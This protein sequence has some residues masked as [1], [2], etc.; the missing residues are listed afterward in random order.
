L[1]P[2]FLGNGKFGAMYSGEICSEDG[3]RVGRLVKVA[4]KDSREDFINQAKV[5]SQLHHPN[6]LTIEAITSGSEPMTLVYEPAGHGSLYQYLI[7]HSPNN[8]NFTRD[9]AL[10]DRA[11]LLDISRQIAAGMAYLSS[12][13]YVH[14]ELMTRNCQVAHSMVIKITDFT[15]DRDV[16][17]FRQQNKRPIA[18]GWMAPETIQTETYTVYS[19]VWAFGI[20]LWEIFTYGFQPYFGFTFPEVREKILNMVLLEQPRDCI[21]VIYELMRNCWTKT[22]THR[23][24]FADLHED[25]NSLC[26]EYL[27]ED[28]D[29]DDEH[30]SCYV[31]AVNL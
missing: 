23:P 28:E 16:C 13:G 15:V 8:P 21:P 9:H 11:N 26:N 10:L 31:T 24:Q 5:W 29:D 25:L 22:P 7:Y 6:L 1:L 27:E 18:L 20:L 2:K 12:H 3:S 19:D 4:L 30:D 17:Y 14:G